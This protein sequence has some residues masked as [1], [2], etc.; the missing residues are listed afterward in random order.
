MFCQAVWNKFQCSAINLTCLFLSSKKGWTLNRR[1]G[2]LRAKR[3]CV[4]QCNNSQCPQDSGFPPVGELRDPRPRRIWSRHTEMLLPLPK[5]KVRPWIH[6]LASQNEGFHSVSNLHAVLS[7]A[8][9]YLNLL[10]QYMSWE[11][12][13]S[14]FGVLHLR[15][16]C[17]WRLRTSERVKLTPVR[18]WLNSE[19]THCRKSIRRAFFVCVCIYSYFA[20]VSWWAAE[21]DTSSANQTKLTL[22]ATK[23]HFKRLYFPAGSFS[24]F[25][26]FLSTGPVFSVPWWFLWFLHVLLLCVAVF[27]PFSATH[28]HFR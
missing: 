5:F 28:T 8:E 24:F 22:D 16:L 14:V 26:F 1:V 9:T 12:I 7:R 20:D 6:T 4:Y 11:W 25:F 21:F 27:M 18:K 10:E 17:A 19:S 15:N 23:K 2:C 3:V 13:P